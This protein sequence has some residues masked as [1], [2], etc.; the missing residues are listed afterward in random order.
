MLAL[1]T[2]GVNR[3]IFRE[4]SKA[5]LKSSVFLPLLTPVMSASFTLIS[6][7]TVPFSS[8]VALPGSLLDCILLMIFSSPPCVG[9]MSTRT[10]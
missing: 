3:F 8:K 5:G 1:D 7:S 6:T 4:D 10:F 2:D 9:T